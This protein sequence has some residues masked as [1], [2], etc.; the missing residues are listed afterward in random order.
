MDFATERALVRSAEAPPLL[1]DRAPTVQPVA[2]RR[3]VGARVRHARRRQRQQLS[4]DRQH[5]RPCPSGQD[6]DCSNT[7]EGRWNFTDLLEQAAKAAGDWV[8]AA[9]KPE[10][11]SDL[12]RAP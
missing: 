1:E 9:K 2:P 11:R 6:I 3:R 5:H 8:E 4:H 7:P 10:R 12:V